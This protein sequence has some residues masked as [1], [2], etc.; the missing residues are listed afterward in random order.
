MLSIFSLLHF[1]LESPLES[2]KIYK[3]KF[4]E[5]CT[6]RPR[7]HHNQPLSPDFFKSHGFDFF[8]KLDMKKGHIY[9]RVK[10]PRLV[11]TPDVFFL[12]RRT[13]ECIDRETQGIAQGFGLV[14]RSSISEVLVR[15]VLLSSVLY[16]MIK[17]TKS[18]KL[19]LHPS[20]ASRLLQAY[21]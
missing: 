6:A 16:R 19:G 21:R 9:E 2:Q 12:V 8:V 20:C 15:V 14:Y 1:S 11:D 10:V 18:H 5:Q 3:T 13:Y 17:Y 7:Q 4:S